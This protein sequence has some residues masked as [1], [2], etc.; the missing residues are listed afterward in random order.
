MATSSGR[1]KYND[2]YID[3]ST[4]HILKAPY[5][6]VVAP[7]AEKVN[8]ADI[9]N[10]LNVTTEYT[11]DH[12]N[13]I[14]WGTNISANVNY[15][16]GTNA[17][18]SV[19]RSKNGTKGYRGQEPFFHPEGG[20]QFTWDAK[21]PEDYYAEN[22]RAV[23][24]VE[25]PEHNEHWE[26]PIIAF[27]STTSTA[28]NYR[29]RENNLVPVAPTAIFEIDVPTTVLSARQTVY[30][31]RVSLSGIDAPNE[32]IELPN[33]TRTVKYIQNKNIRYVLPQVYETYIKIA[34]KKIPIKFKNPNYVVMQA[35]DSQAIDVPL[36]DGSS[37]KMRDYQWTVV[38]NI[39][40]E[41]ELVFEVPINLKD[42]PDLS[43]NLSQIT[44][45]YEKNVEKQ[46]GRTGNSHTEFAYSAPVTVNPQNQYI[47]TVPAE[48]QPSRTYYSIDN[49]LEAFPT[50]LEPTKAVI[51]ENSRIFVQPEPMGT[52]PWMY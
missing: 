42:R 36:P 20:W 16:L 13:V 3:M 23:R 46:H 19:K 25:L 2:T 35:S 21:L 29:F 44:A 30:K 50:T 22:R 8:P 15:G 41:T 49:A 51:R 7:R 47:E 40:A 48:L 12:F 38:Q 1:P 14:P 11:S 10:E 27:P 18:S 24:Y 34:E 28:H 17:N 33:P 52:F 37:F 39:D 9:L 6:S 43:Y 31:G 5:Q 26:D 45:D 32:Q 4:A